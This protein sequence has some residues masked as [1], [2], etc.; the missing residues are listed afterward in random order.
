MFRGARF[1]ES[2]TAQD[3][4][5]TSMATAHVSAAAALVIASGVVG[6]KPS[7][8]HVQRRLEQT[9]RD[10]GQPGYDIRYGWGLVNAAA[11]TAPTATSTAASIRMSAGSR[12]HPAE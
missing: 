3:Y 5:G 2:A 9:A 7:P 11:A 12:L 10:L 6:T 4:S 1:G 8:L